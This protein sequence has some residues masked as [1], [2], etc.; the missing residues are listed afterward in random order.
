MFTEL[1]PATGPVTK[2]LL[3]YSQSED[4][5]SP[6][7]E[8]QTLK[9]SNNG[10]I[11][12]PWTA[13]QVSADAISPQKALTTEPDQYIMGA[14][15]GPLRVK[16]GQTVVLTSTANAGGA[17]TVE[18]GGA[19]DIEG[20]TL[21]GPLKASGAALLRICGASVAGPVNA[22]NG[23]G[24][25]VIGEGTGGCSASTF[26][27][28][29][30]EGNTAGVSIDGN[31]FEGSLKVTG[32][33][34]GTTVTNNNVHGSLTVTGNTGRSWTNPTKS[35]GNRNSSRGFRG[36]LGAAPSVSGRRCPARLKASRRASERGKGSSRMEGGKVQSARF[37]GGFGA[38]LA[39]MTQYYHRRAGRTAEGRLRVS[40]GSAGFSR[41][42]TGD[43]WS[44]RGGWGFHQASRL[45]TEAS[46]ELPGD[47]QLG[48]LL[49]VTPSPAL[50]GELQA[51][52]W[53][54][55]TTRAIAG[56]DRR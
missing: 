4:V 37:A 22:S 49:V 43:C 55:S 23:S 27:G 36:P 14:V 51:S 6:F 17:V 1:D 42:S 29:L 53:C 50:V 56:G 47:G 9:F 41:R 31:V 3:T 30:L 24:P 15:N 38:R 11:T 33:A 26:Y 5:T 20:A 34:G 39:P 19:L 28:R 2:G 52:A 25:V 13:S 8:D 16:A 35:K 10:W 44:D 48:G 21:S 18:P 12:L 45:R 32:N 7:Y 54:P 40:A 46:I